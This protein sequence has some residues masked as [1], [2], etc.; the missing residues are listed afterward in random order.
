MCLTSPTRTA[1]ST[2]ST[3]MQT[4]STPGWLSKRKWSAR[5]LRPIKYAT[6]PVTNRAVPIQA[7]TRWKYARS[8][9]AGT[10]VCVASGRTGGDYALRR[11]VPAVALVIRD[12]GADDSQ[13]VADLL[14]Q[15]GYPCSG[16]DVER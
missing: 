4:T 8:S 1:T 3:M 2:N 14:T 7:K 5:E 11:R 13:A 16:G 15:L 6:S 10:I 9:C 12:A